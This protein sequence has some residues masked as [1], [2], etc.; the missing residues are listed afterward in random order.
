MPAA[1]AGLALLVARPAA[2]M[3]EDLAVAP[4]ARAIGEATTATIDDAWAFYYN[5]AML[6]RLA[7]PQAAFTTV[8]PNGLGFN[9]LRSA[10]VAF[11]LRGRGGALAVGYRNY[12]VDYGDVQLQSENTLSVAQGF[13]LFGDASTSASIGWALNFYHAEFA[14]SVGAS[15]DGSNGIDPGSA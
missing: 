9:R 7:M 2:A 12:G 14:T 10:A 6:S 8:E 11:P 13:H 15:G 5:P 1:L 3:F 4:R